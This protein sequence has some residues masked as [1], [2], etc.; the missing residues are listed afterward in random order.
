MK[1]LITLMAQALVDNPDQVTVTEVEG[2]QTSV[3]E[4]KVAK[5][6][7]GKVIGKEGRNARAMRTILGAA[8]AKLKK[9]TVLEIIE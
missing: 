6:D 7:L 2:N 5:E 9:R 4:L 8:S 3:I 1:D